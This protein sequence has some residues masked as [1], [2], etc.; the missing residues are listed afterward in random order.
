M[1]TSEVINENEYNVLV[2][3]D[4]GVIREV[5]KR[6]LVIAGYKVVLAESGDGVIKAIA[7]E[8]IRVVVLDIRM[9]GKSGIEVLE[10]IKKK[11]PD[12]EVV[13]ITAYSSDEQVSRLKD[14]GIVEILFKPF[15]HI[16][17]VVEAVNR[18]ILRYDLKTQGEISDSPAF[19]HFLLK[20]ENL[21]KEKLLE[22][23]DKAKTK[24]LSLADMLKSQKD[25]NQKKFVKDLSQYLGVPFASMNDQSIALELLLNFPA[26]LARKHNC[27]P[28]LRE[29]K[30]LHVAISN[31]FNE[32]AR[33]DIRSLMNIQ[34]LFHIAH[35]NEISEIINSLYS[36]SQKLESDE[37]LA[38]V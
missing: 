12:V 27:F 24:R 38:I 10:E 35:E 1:N 13:M 19:E 8:S 9:P 20:S 33:K 37:L 4:A 32:E 26:K 23:K 5:C 28:L 18:A 3:D 16:S 36:D 34:P 22:A 31:P 17:I 30:K 7:H 2:V 15:K 25:M 14:T 11:Y 29:G 21:T 6:A